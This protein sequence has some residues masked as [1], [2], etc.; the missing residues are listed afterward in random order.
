MNHFKTLLALITLLCGAA[1]L[2]VMAASSAA[3]SASDSVS[4][5]VGSVSDSIQKSSESSTGKNTVAD[6]DYRVLDV[7][8]AAERP[9]LVRVQLQALADPTAEGGLYLFVPQATVAQGQLAVGQVITA[10][11]HAY[12]V[13]FAKA[14]TRQAFFLAMNDAWH[15]E[16][17]SN[18]VTL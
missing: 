7:A 9:G 13:E 6:G 8:L 17:K 1:A 12:G 16:L 10:R 18:P 4:T 15:R 2:P 5:S 14:D 11:N 3:S